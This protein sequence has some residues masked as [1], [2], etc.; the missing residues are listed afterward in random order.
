MPLDNGLMYFG[1]RERMRWVPAAAPGAGFN[2]VG[3]SDRIDYLGGGAGLRNSTGAHMEYELSWGSLTRDQIAQIEDYAYGLYGDGLIYFVDPIAMDRNMFS[4]QWAAPKITAEDGIPLTGTNR[5]AKV[6]INDM[7]L[8]YPMYAAQYTVAAGQAGLSFHCPI[9]PG[10]T[11]W[12]GAHGTA[13]AQGLRV[14]P[15][16]NGT[17]TGLSTAVPVLAVT[18]SNR[19][20]ASFDNGTYNGIDISIDST[21]AATITLAGLMLQLLPT[22]DT[23]STGGFI[24]GRGNSG[25]VFDGKPKRM[26]YSIPGESIGM[27]AS[28]VE[29]GDWQ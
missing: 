21:S 2:A 12:V 13:G 19:F 23:P 9:P 7:S 4:M 16:L 3:Y 1:T 28:L 22:G 29:V 10:Y 18:N 8:G 14:Q 26:P 15:T 11:A 24:S 20:S 17:A 25:C 6:L 5:P 27:S